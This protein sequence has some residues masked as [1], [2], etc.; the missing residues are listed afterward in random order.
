M[1]GT[2]PRR[3]KRAAV[4]PRERL[5]DRLHDQ[6]DA[7][8]ISNPSAKIG[9]TTKK[10]GVPESCTELMVRGEELVPTV[11]S[12][13]SRRD[14]PAS[15]LGARSGEGSRRAASRVASAKVAGSLLSRPGPCSRTAYSARLLYNPRRGGVDG[16]TGMVRRGARPVPQDQGPVRSQGVSMMN[17]VR[18]EGEVG[19]YEPPHAGGAA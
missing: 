13:W 3:P 9:S 11:D 1:L 6:A 4:E 17:L 10:T 15:R 5:V 2:D 8:P 12:P 18:C 7:S 16:P 19:L 14:V